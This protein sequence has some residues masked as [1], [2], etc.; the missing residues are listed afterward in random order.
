MKTAIKHFIHTQ[1][2]QSVSHPLNQLHMLRKD[3]NSASETNGIGCHIGTQETIYL[4]IWLSMLV[5]ITQFQNL[6]KTLLAERAYN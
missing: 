2:K 5:S 3:P 4:N 1:K 6:V